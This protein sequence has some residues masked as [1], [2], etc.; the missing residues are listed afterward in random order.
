MN[1]TEN[2]IKLME[3]N[4]IM[5]QSELQ[6]V[7]S[8]VSAQLWAA[9]STLEDEIPEVGYPLA[10][11]LYQRI[12]V[13]LMELQDEMQRLEV[14]D[15]AGKAVREQSELECIVHGWVNESTLRLI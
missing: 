14:E 12:E 13:M 15:I 1:D 5:R 10:D 11:S 6:G 8:R 7:Y 3:R 2:I 9:L 4:K